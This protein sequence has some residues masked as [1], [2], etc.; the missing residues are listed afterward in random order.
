MTIDVS[1]FGLKVN[2]TASVTFPMGIE[3]T[4]FSDDTDP[5]DM[6]SIQVRDKAAG[7]NGDLIVW[8]KANAVPMTL[9]VLPNTPDD[10]NLQILARA[11][12]AARGRRAVQDEITATVAYP[13]GRTLRLL[14]G[15]I[16]DGIIGDAVASS[17][18]IKTKP[19]IFAFEDVQ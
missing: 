1:A 17:G 13:D 12:R 8:S 6:A 9:A 2:L 4:A 18:R 14:R 7:V 10:Q 15:V 11:N 16:T 3:I 19:Y 5:V